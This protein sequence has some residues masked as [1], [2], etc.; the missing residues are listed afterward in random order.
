MVS[1][2]ESVMDSNNKMFLSVFEFD[3]KFNVLRIFS[4]VCNGPGHH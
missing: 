4:S 2:L 1:P 3:E